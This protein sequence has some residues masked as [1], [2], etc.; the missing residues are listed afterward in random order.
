LVGLIV[1]C[2]DPVDEWRRDLPCIVAISSYSFA[3]VILLHSTQPL[4]DEFSNAVIAVACVGI[5]A[6]RGLFYEPSR[7]SGRRHIAGPIVIVAAA[8]FAAAGVRWY[9]A[10]ITWAATAMLLGAFAI[11]GR[12]TPL[13]RYVRGS[14]A[15][16]LVSFIAFTA[17]AGP[18]AGLFFQSRSAAARN[19]LGFWYDGSFRSA[20]LEILQLPRFWLEKTSS[21]RTGF[22]ASGGNTNIIIPVRDDD[23]ERPGAPVSRAHA[24][25]QQPTG[26][27]QA[28]K[29]DTSSLTRSNGTA[30]P[31]ADDTPRP[32]PAR[33]PLEHLKE[34][35]RTVLP[36]AA[37]DPQRAVPRTPF[38]HLKAVTTGLAII[39]VP[40][41][42][43]Q[44]IANVDLPGGRGLLPISDLDTIWLD[45]SIALMLV[46][47]W[48]RRHALGHGAPVVLFGLLLSA[49]AAVL[50]GYVVTNFGTLWR[51]RA[52]V[53]VPVWV[54][55]VAL[56]PER[57]ARPV[58]SEV[59]GDRTDRAELVG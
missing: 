8:T 43:V 34:V 30:L 52:F 36:G 57:E 28:S 58:P 18:Y 3:P 5:H 54:L 2:F 25:R 44:A 56:T 35:P 12:T 51:L 16:L 50:M 31:E 4:K 33:T 46:L 55:G 24:P 13:L 14:A 11:R 26:N 39:F 37:D 15:V 38:E 42:L 40:I 17:G 49:A 47:L 6:L 21:A 53:A 20:V 45:A 23:D 59:H 48:K 29:W 32:D 27:L 9:F 7:T 10:I 22:L 1:W 41:S 19:A